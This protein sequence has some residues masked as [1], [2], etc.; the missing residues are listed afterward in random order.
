M[1]WFYQIIKV[2]FCVWLS[3]KSW[4]GHSKQAN[5]GQFQLLEALCHYLSKW[6]WASLLLQLYIFLPLIPHSVFS[7]GRPFPLSS[8]GYSIGRCASFSI[9]Q[10]PPLPTQI[11]QTTPLWSLYYRYNHFCFPSIPSLTAPV[12]S[13]PNPISYICCPYHSACVKS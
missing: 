5:L 12:S 6:N 8:V 3:N 7:P 2:T 11:F 4:M 1:K 9:C 13:L 10:I